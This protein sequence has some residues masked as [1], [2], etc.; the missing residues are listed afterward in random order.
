MTHKKK[1]A[2]GV[3]AV[4]FFTVFLN[5]LSITIIIPILAPFLL[6]PDSSVIETGTAFGNI[7]I[8]IGLL[9]AAY[10]VSQFVGAPV[11]GAISDRV[12]RKKV[13]F[14]SLMGSFIGYVT[15]ALGIIY[16]NLWL[17]FFSRILDGLTGGNISVAYSAIADVSSNEEKSK[18][19]GLIGAAFGLGFVIGPFIGGVCSD[20]DVVSWFGFDTPFWLSA[21]LVLVN[22]FLVWHIF[23]ETLRKDDRVSKTPK[24]FGVYLRSFKLVR[25]HPMQYLFLVLFL[26]FF[27]Y[28][29]YTQFLDVFLIEKFDYSQS[30]IGILFG[31]LGIWISF[32]QGFL[33]RWAS[34]KFASKYIVA[35]SLIGAAIV[36]FSILSIEEALFLYFILPFN[37]ILQG[38]NR[39][40]LLSL[41]SN[42]VGKSFQG[43]VMGA[44]Q[45]IQSLG[46][47]LPPIISG[48]I[49][50][51]NI[52]LPIIA[53]A[54]CFVVAWLVFVVYTFGRNKR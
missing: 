54:V 35:F 11:L 2:N 4:I 8:I 32:S 38:L 22:I 53:G 17:L 43:Q 50:A 41:I 40:N 6:S 23:P 47:A 27:G 52:N 26:S 21:I 42:G 48:F 28:T 30:D 51:L 45:S 39:P 13:L 5:L 46:I 29:F 19:F 14:Y 44:S 34:Q 3:L 12:G 18:N 20:P 10:P 7:T 15:F 24:F 16:G 37:S 1:N 36:F 9:K 33:N 31:Y 49:I 25:Q